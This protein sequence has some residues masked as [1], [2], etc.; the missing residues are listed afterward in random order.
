MNSKKPNP[1]EKSKP[2]PLTREE[3]RLVAGGP[4]IKNG[5]GGGVYT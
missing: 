4:E 3:V 5:G 2:R 1:G